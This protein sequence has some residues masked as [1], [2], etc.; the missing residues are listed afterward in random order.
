MSAHFSMGEF[1]SPSMVNGKANYRKRLQV[2][3]R[4]QAN[5]RKLMAQLE[6]QMLDHAKNLEFEE[7]ASLRDEIRQIREERLI[8]PA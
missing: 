3:A 1:S 2:P 5:V 7:A 6:Q 8:N 4:Y